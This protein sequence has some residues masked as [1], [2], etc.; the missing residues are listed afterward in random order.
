MS[1]GRQEEMEFSLHADFHYHCVI[2]ESH[3]KSLTLKTEWKAGY[4][5]TNVGELELVLS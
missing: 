5:G 3:T 2:L 4:M 1:S